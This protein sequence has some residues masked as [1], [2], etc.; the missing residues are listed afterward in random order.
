[1]ARSIA[2]KSFKG[3]DAREEILKY[4]DRAAKDPYFFNRAYKDT[5]PTP[6]Y[7]EVEE[8]EDDDIKSLKIMTGN[9]RLGQQKPSGFS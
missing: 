2:N 6:V 1:M 7:A 8:D 4:A 3:V 9:E 5:Q